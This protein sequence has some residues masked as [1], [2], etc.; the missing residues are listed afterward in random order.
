[1]RF[2]LLEVEAHLARAFDLD[3]LDVGEHRAKAQAALG[4]QQVEGVAHVFGGDRR[5]VGET[6]LGVEVEAQRQAVVG[7]FHLLGHQA[8]DG[9]GLIQ[10]AL[11]QGEYSQP[12]TW[13]TPMPLSI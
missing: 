5:A 7:A 4:H 9:V 2:S 8:V 13:D 10:G 12:S 1:V 3:V 6:C 11:G